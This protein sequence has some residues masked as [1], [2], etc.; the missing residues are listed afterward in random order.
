MASENDFAH[1]NWL[2]GYVTYIRGDL[3]IK[4]PLLFFLSGMVFSLVATKFIFFYYA[5]T[6]SLIISY[7]SMIIIG[8]FY[9]PN[10]SLKV[11][12]Y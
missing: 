12:S 10:S 8:S 3:G 5:V 2:W 9:S 7:A 6:A 4:E 1:R 11:C